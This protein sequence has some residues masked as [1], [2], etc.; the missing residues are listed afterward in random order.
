MGGD[1]KG[2]L[3]ILIVNSDG[4]PIKT[5]IDD[6]NLSNQYAQLITALA[7]KARH[8][9]RDLD[10]TNELTFLR[11]R[12]RKHEIMV[13]PDKDYL[14]IVVQDPNSDGARALS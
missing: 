6:A 5:T 14:L 8:C 12:S 13:A 1:C 4:A 7:S 2:V 3:G 9:V 11:I 10:P